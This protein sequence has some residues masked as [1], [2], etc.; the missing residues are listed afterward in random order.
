MLQPEGGGQGEIVLCLRLLTEE[1]ERAA[2]VDVE[3]RE[4]AMNA[5]VIRRLCP[6]NSFLVPPALRAQL[7]LIAGNVVRGEGVV[8]S[9]DMPLGRKM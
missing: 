2:E 7:L 1:L 8:F 3:R 4:E 9:I 5:L 6:R